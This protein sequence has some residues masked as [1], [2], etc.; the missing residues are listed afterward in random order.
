MTEEPD[1]S[2]ELKEYKDLQKK[3]Q[4]IMGLRNKVGAALDQVYQKGDFSP[5]Q[6]T[7]FLNNPEHFSPQQIQTIEKSREEIMAF[8]WDVLGEKKKAQHEKKILKKK[9]KKRRGK[10]LGHRR[11]W[12]K[13]D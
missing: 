5:Q 9:A 1:K 2:Q 6:V 4:V 11:K 7:D 10:S 3:L 13:M 8:I 12:L